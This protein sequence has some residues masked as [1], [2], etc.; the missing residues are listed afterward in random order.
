[1]ERLGDRDEYPGVL[2]VADQGS[3]IYSYLVVNGPTYGT[4]WNGR[5]DFHPT[6][7]PFGVWY[8]R[9]GEKALRR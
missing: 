7:L 6:G 5:E 1:M 3:A 4:L 9:W 8:R 2:E